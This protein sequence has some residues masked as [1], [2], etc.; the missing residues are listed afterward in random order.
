MK[1][2]PVK[3]L[4][5]NKIYANIVNTWIKFDKELCIQKISQ[6]LP[7]KYYQLQKEKE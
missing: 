1:Y 4:E 3:K 7:T 6:N 5:I 2:N